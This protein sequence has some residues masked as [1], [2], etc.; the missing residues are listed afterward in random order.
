MQTES[1]HPL[2]Q[3][4]PANEICTPKSRRC[5]AKMKYCGQHANQDALLRTL[6]KFIPA[7]IRFRNGFAGILILIT[8]P[9]AFKKAQIL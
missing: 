6:I 4:L 7:V 5:V 2:L 3:K 1:K 9:T 8:I